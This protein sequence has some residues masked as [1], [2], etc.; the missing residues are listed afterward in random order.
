ME[1]YAATRSS[2][3]ETNTTEIDIHPILLSLRDDFPD[4]S[5]NSVTCIWIPV[6]NVDNE[7]AF[8]MYNNIM[9]DKRT[10]L[11]GRHHGNNA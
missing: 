2:V 7:R 11:G 6:S 8:S 9:T 1:G 4:N 3:L 10:S 5:A